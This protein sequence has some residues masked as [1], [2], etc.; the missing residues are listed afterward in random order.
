MNINSLN[1]L[2]N[3]LVRPET[4]SEWKEVPLQPLTQSLISRFNHEG[5][6]YCHWKSK[7][8][9][10]ELDIDLLVSIQ[11]LATALEVLMQ[12]GF[13]A[14]SPRWG[15][16]LPGEF[17]YY[18]YDADNHEY[19]HLHL[20]THVLSGERLVKSHW[21]P[22]EE[23]MLKDSYS[24]NGLVVT[25]KESE[26]ILFILKTYIR[27]GSILDTLREDESDEELKTEL[28]KF[29]ADSDMAKVINLLNTYCPVIDEHIFL[30]CVSAI[31]EDASFLRKWMLA[32][33]I[34]RR[35]HA[36]SLNNFVGRW[37]RYVGFLGAVLRKK[38]RRQKGNK[39]LVAGGAII[40]IVGADATGKS[41]LVEETSRWLREPFIVNTS[42]A[43]KPPSA[44]LT[45]PINLLLTLNRNLK[46]KVKSKSLSDDVPGSGA[47]FFHDGDQKQGSLTYAIRAVCLAFD[48]RN[49]LLK[50][51]RAAAQGE[52]VVCDRY[53]TNST[54]MMDSPRL[55]ENSVQKGFPK[56]ILNWLARLERNIYYKIP[57]PDIVLR[58]K[59]SL[60]IAKERNATR[61]IVD[62]ET[63]LQLRHQ[64]TE[65]WFVPGT[66][67]ISDIDTDNSLTET[68]SAVKKVIWAN[69]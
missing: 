49:L 65:D 53:P 62:D 7:L 48:R 16:N 60:E 8:L 37:S 69:I 32:Q 59:V 2:N 36:Y 68:I 35:L 39:R 31:Q 47:T 29:I 22:F 3:V 34:R 25:S 56:P 18:G 4:P 33:R 5:V 57:P 54:G 42:H 13:K 43:G 10:G 27:Y 38:M 14:A 1:K 51:R 24:I 6:L 55:V 58:L 12:M 45:L 41:T 17:H 44:L 46:R 40:A 28:K 26:F 61:E 9:D 52:F 67:T 66:R 21:F 20:F 19:V 50:T 64:Q 30:N 63:Y 15:E 11:S 23:M